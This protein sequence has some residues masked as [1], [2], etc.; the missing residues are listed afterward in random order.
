MNEIDY[1]DVFDTCPIRVTPGR[2]LRRYEALEGAY[3][4][5]ADRYG[6]AIVQLEALKPE[7]AHA[8]LEEKQRELDAA[9]VRVRVYEEEAASRAEAAIIEHV[10][11]NQDELLQGKLSGQNVHIG[12]SFAYV[13]D[14]AAPQLVNDPSPALR[15][16][17]L[18]NEREQNAAIVPC[19][20][21]YACET[22]L[23][24]TQPKKCLTCKKPVDFVMA[25]IHAPVQ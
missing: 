18:C 9:L 23:R 7:V 10:V 8:I 4:R 13:F 14:M 12:D 11:P 16:C 22:C 24:I 2:L 5:M 21:C 25:L 20:H 1:I 15:I 6:A 3:D 19:G 17:L